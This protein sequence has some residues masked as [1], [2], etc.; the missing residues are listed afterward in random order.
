MKIIKASTPKEFHEIARMRY[1]IYY[2]ECQKKHLNGYDHARKILVSCKDFNEP[3]LLY[4]LKEGEML[5][6][7][8]CV[9]SQYNNH[10]RE[11][12]KIPFIAPGI[13]YAEVDC[14][15]IN[16]AY[17]R[18][19]V[20]FSLAGDIYKR[21]LM[22]GVHI[23][24]IEAETHLLKFYTRLGFKV[25][26]KTKYDFGVRFQLYLNLWDLTALQECNSPF[27]NLLENYHLNIK[28]KSIKNE[29]HHQL[30]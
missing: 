15:V 17:R 7:L 12:Y 26:C 5:G 1:Q 21:G 28:T 10:I 23:C 16:E 14:F 19:R 25:I 18:S 3:D 22:N 8:R 2:D 6:S 4:A 9:Y 29:E 13:K 20:A 24:L 11:K 30:I 27:K